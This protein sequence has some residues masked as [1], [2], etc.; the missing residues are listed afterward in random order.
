MEIRWIRHDK[1]TSTNLYLQEQIKQKK[2]EE[3]VVVIADY[4]EAGR[5][6]G[7]NSWHSR[8]GE[9]LLMSVLLFPAFLSASQQFQLSRLISVSLCELLL[10]MGIDS[11][12]KWPND[13]LVRGGK[14]AGILIEHG[15]SGKLI[16]HT[17]AGIGLNLNQKVFP[18]FPQPASSVILETGRTFPNSEVAEKLLARISFWYE[19]IRVGDSKDLESKYLESLFRLGTPS[20]FE[21]GGD[22]FEGIIRGVSPYGELQVESQGRLLTFG[23][24]EITLKEAYRT[25]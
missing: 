11:S 6:Q 10:S 9:N 12:I 3:G 25:G 22:S 20:R 17:I 5:G 4:Q 21:A 15:I 24:G 23:H 16:S 8:A 19:E 2:V 1:L 18:E 13:I 7:T 14:I